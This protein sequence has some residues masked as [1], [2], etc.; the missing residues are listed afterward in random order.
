MFK[1]LAIKREIECKFSIFS[2]ALVN[3][4]VGRIWLELVTALP[5][6]RDCT[7]PYNI[8]TLHAATRNLNTQLAVNEEKKKWPARYHTYSRL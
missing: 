6:C 4:W 7:S 1:I 3:A 2:C 5:C 8:L